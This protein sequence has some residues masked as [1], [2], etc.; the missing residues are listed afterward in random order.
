MESIK[1]TI[2]FVLFVIASIEG[3]MLHSTI[4]SSKD[5]EL[6]YSKLLEKSQFLQKEIDRLK[7][8][9]NNIQVPDL[10]ED[11]VV[12]YWKEFLK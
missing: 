1:T 9:V 10:K 8:E 12:D 5:F 6:K 4:Q 7:K 3:F 2:I 11:E